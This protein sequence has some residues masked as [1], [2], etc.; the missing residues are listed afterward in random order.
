MH[1]VGKA[2]PG[3]IV[4]LPADAAAVRAQTNHVLDACSSSM[5]PGIGGTL[6]QLVRLMFKR[7]QFALGLD[8]D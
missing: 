1:S 6:P 8:D 2:N 5:V 3:E 7:M 4:E